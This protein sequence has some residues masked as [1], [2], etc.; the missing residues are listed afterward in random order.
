[1]DSITTGVTVK[2]VNLQKTGATTTRE[3]VPAA[4]AGD[5]FSP[6]VST[7]IQGRPVFEAGAT[8]PKRTGASLMGKSSPLTGAALTMMNSPVL[9]SI[10]GTIAKWLISDEEEMKLGE[11]L[12]SQIEAQMPM[13]DDPALNERVQRIGKGIASHSKRPNL[14]YS[15]KVVEDDTINAFAGP[16]GKVYVHKGLLEKFPSDAHLAFIMGHEMGHVENRDAI[17]RLGVMFVLN[18]M[19]IVLK[20]TPGKIDDALGGA[21]GMLYDSR[22]SQKA[23]YAADRRGVDHMKALGF[24]GKQGA[25]ALRGL[26]SAGKEE[27][28]LLERLFSSHPPTEK[29]AQRAQEYATK[30]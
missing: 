21:V 2:P 3:S 23:E 22:L 24:D 5:G 13:S 29:R 18:I 14:D 25:E 15:F 12:S 26:D 20:E 10:P 27:P 30:A 17:D 7:E 19:Q 16:G 9:M 4:V 8:M 6:S 1:M 28:T 11:M